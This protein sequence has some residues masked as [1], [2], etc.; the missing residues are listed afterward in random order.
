MK[1]RP[2]RSG[3]LTGQAAA[4]GG[5]LPGSRV[6]SLQAHGLH[7][8]VDTLVRDQ[9]AQR[10]QAR[11]HPAHARIAPRVRVNLLHDRDQR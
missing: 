10:R 2:T 6:A 9:V 3:A 4:D 11:A 8:P 1:S 7:Q 5:P